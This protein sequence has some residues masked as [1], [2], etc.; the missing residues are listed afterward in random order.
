MLNTLVQSSVKVEPD[1]AALEA[2]TTG[3]VLMYF[4]KDTT[5]SK[6]IVSVYVGG[7]SGVAATYDI[8]D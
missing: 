6:V 2:L 8:T 5:N 3:Q 1:A 7:M 4:N